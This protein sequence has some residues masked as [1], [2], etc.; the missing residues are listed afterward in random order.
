MDAAL[1]SPQTAEPDARA[2]APGPDASEPEPRRPASAA[3]LTL[4]ALTLLGLLVA[5]A[6]QQPSVSALLDAAAQQRTVYRYDRALALAQ[7]AR[8]E[9]P[10]APQPAC[11]AGMTLTLQREASQAAAAYQVCATLA[12]QDG[13]A[14]LALGDALAASASPHDSP[15]AAS[16]WTH[17]ANL[18]VDDAWARLAERAEQLGDLT[19]A[20]AAWARVAP[21][22]ANAELAAAH[23]GL[24]ALARGDAGAA[25]AH[26]ARLA[27]AGSSDALATQL[28]DAGVFFF[29]QQTPQFA[30]DW[31]GI[32][33]ALLSLSLPALALG[34]FQRALALAPS[35]PSAT[36]YTGYTLWTLGQRAAARPLIAAGVSGPLVLP[37]GWYA[38][39][40]VAQADGHAALALKDYQAGL[41]GD[42]RNAA[43]WQAAGDAAVASQDYLT[44]QL[45]YQN[46]AQYSQTPGAT[47]ALISF[48]LTQGIG[49]SDGTAL[50]AIR[51]GLERFPDS[52]RLLCL[53]A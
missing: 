6:P 36:A 32:G 31:V 38:A 30:Q 18:G 23:L 22:G 8:A 10:A 7:M 21:D 46:A 2:G 25:R 16:A 44:A 33:H 53:E 19:G 29:D 1:T 14:W 40:V 45:S 26:L 5:L 43:L 11:D 15:A 49:I 3:T 39:G 50:T 13:A 52:E 28:R 41:R 24:L 34:P 17:A 4:L 51:T 42:P 35:D 47:I 37:F 12:P 20:G 48:Y 9:A 27:S